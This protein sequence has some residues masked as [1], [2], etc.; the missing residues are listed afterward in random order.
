MSLK[1]TDST[2]VSSG[3]DQADSLVP[4]L[5]VTSLQRELVF[6]LSYKNLECE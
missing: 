5:P 6:K 3:G 1:I 2:A 4:I